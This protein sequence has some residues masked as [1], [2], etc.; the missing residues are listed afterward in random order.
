MYPHNRG[1]PMPS[2][3]RLYA[4]IICRKVL[5]QDGVA[6]DV[7]VSN[8][9]S[10]S[11]SVVVSTPSQL[12]EAVRSG[13]RHV[14]ISDHMDLTQVPRFSQTT[15]L[16]TSVLAVGQTGSGEYTA[17]IQ[18]RSTAPAVSSIP[19][20]TNHT[21]TSNTARNHVSTVVIIG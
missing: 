11:E 14:I 7:V 10:L 20:P 6:A 15:V 8:P 21:Q 12:Q 16:D 17:S 5:F 3:W 1:L 18:V 13:K 19:T 4:A 9:G 2:M